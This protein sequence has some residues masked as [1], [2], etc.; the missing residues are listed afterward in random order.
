MLLGFPPYANNNTRQI[1]YSLKKHPHEAC[2][3]EP[4][5]DCLDLSTD[6][7]ALLELQIQLRNFGKLVLRV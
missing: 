6:V 2:D 1:T 5:G 7:V 3:L 4:N